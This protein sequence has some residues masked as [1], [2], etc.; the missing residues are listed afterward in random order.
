[1]CIT[2]RRQMH[3]C[4]FN[5][6]LF[7]KKKNISLQPYMFATRQLNTT[8]SYLVTLVSSTRRNYHFTCFLHLHLIV[9][10]QLIQWL[11]L[12]HS[13]MLSVSWLCLASRFID[14][15]YDLFPFMTLLILSISFE[16]EFP[17]TILNFFLFWQLIKLLPWSLVLQSP[18][19]TFF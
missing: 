14:L 13:L 3:H 17:V 11:L 7:I 10:I 6:S 19:L 16:T 8:S 15:C 12:L 4:I 18:S 2:L 9:I 1:M 5:I